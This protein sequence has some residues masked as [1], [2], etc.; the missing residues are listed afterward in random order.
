[1]RS[2]RLE[3]RPNGTEVSANQTLVLP[4][5]AEPGR[6]ADIVTVTGVS[7]DSVSTT[8]PRGGR[9]PRGGEDQGSGLFPE[10]PLIPETHDSPQ[11]S[12]DSAETEL[13]LPS[14]NQEVSEGEEPEGAGPEGEELHTPP[15]WIH[16]K[17]TA[18]FSL[19]R[20]PSPPP[21][22]V[23][24]LPSLPPGQDVLKVDFFDP[25][26]R[27][28]GL[29]LAPPPPS[30]SQAELQGGDPTSWAVPDDYDYLT[31]YEE[32]V[33]PTAGDYDLSTTDSY[34][35]RRS[36]SRLPPAAPPSGGRSSDGSD[37]RG[38]CRAGYLR[39]NGVCRST[40]DL[41]RNYCLNGGQCYIQ[42]G[43]GA[44]C[45]CNVQEY[46]WNKGERCESAVTEFQVLCATIGA[47]AVVLLLLFM[48]IVCFT[49]KLHLL[50]T[51][52]KKLRRRRYRVGGGYRGGG[53]R[54]VGTE[55]VGTVEVGTE[56][57][58]TDEVGT[59]EVGTEEVGTEEVGTD[60]VGTEEVGAEEVG[61]KRRGG[62]CR[63][64]G[65]RGG[66]YRGGGCRGEEVGTEEVGA[67]VVGAEEVGTEEVG[68]EEVGTEE[69]GTEEVGTEEVG[70]EEVG[71]EEVGTED[72]C[73]CDG[74]MNMSS[75]WVDLPLWLI[76][77]CR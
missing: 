43:N 3:A 48:I 58:G 60:V 74:I 29:D 41:Q 33:S 11:I 70:T 38:G 10:L 76:L 55:E 36:R 27:G 30:P 7:L 23:P 31:P 17:D 9:V 2:P 22:P 66:G 32:G 64:G 61:T 69:V 6:A 24:S 49:K 52:N 12:Y 73:V 40:C 4:E 26:S 51:Q 42:E 20:L 62:G 14:N 63:G 71:T 28:R 67:E 45:R 16:N 65:Y 5:E 18:V 50:E 57:V 39:E 35:P 53:Y 46:V 21:S 1:M 68:T 75:P 15:P 72:A 44:L 54:E 77:R 13:L 25:S 37:G 47:S 59:V 19:D 56:E 8:S 34:D